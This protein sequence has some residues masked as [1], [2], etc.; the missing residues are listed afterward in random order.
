MITFKD[1]EENSDTFRAYMEEIDARLRKLAVPIHD[2]P[3]RAFQEIARDGMS[4]GI[5]MS[6]S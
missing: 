3:L 5:S 2:R 1:I 6:T 4:V